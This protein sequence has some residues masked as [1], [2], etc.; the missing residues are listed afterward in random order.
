[1]TTIGIGLEQFIR[2]PHGTGMQRVLQQPALRWPACEIQA[3][4]V[5]PNARATSTLIDRATSTE[6]LALPFVERSPGVDLR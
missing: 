6:R 2:D 4:F 5:V 3:E 1:M